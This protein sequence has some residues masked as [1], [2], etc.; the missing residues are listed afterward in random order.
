MSH[1][2]TVHG[3]VV[4]SR[5][6]LCW[7][8]THD[9][10]GQLGRLP[11]VYW[12]RECLCWQ[13]FVGQ[14]TLHT[15]VQWV[16]PAALQFMRCHRRR[17][18]FDRGWQLSTWRN[19]RSVAT[20][21]ATIAAQTIFQHRINRCSVTQPC[22]TS[23]SEW[24]GARWIASSATTKVERNAPAPDNDGWTTGW[25]IDQRRYRASVSQSGALSRRNALPRNELVN[26]DGGPA[27]K[28]DCHCQCCVVKDDDHDD[29]VAR[30]WRS[31]WWRRERT[32]RYVTLPQLDVNRYVRP[33]ALLDDV[34][35]MCVSAHEIMTLLRGMQLSTRVLHSTIILTVYDTVHVILTVIAPVCMSQFT[36]NLPSKPMRYSTVI[37]QPF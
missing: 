3:H 2:S 8:W 10:N 25:G 18:V 35:N 27:C 9:F 36:S 20:N 22:Q 21:R 37:C 24:R 13:Q 28:M 11:V 15:G 16:W 32:I 19:D 4:A 1:S 23:T 31:I 14:F 30:R 34:I 12:I 6:A 33:T 26:V 5:S 7:G 17:Q 29:D